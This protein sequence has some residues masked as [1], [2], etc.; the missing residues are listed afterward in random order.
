[1][2]VKINTTFKTKM[3]Y[4]YTVS[5]LNWKC[6]SGSNLYIKKRKCQVLTN[7]DDTAEKNWNIDGIYVPHTGFV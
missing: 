2:L 4:V 7:K 5:L 1:M 3:T 6:N